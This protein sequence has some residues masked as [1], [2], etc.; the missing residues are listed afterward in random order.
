MLNRTLTTTCRA[1]PLMMGCMGSAAILLWST[2]VACYPTETVY[3]WYYRA[4]FQMGTEILFQQGAKFDPEK[5][6]ETSVSEQKLAEEKKKSSTVEKKAGGIRSEASNHGWTAWLLLKM[7]LVG[8]NR[9]LLS[10]EDLETDERLRA[11]YIEPTTLA[12]V[13]NQDAPVQRQEARRTY[14]L[15]NRDLSFARLQR[16][17]LR[18]ADFSGAQLQGAGLRGANLQNARFGCN[19]MGRSLPG[20]VRNC[21]VQTCER[22]SCRA[23]T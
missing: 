2:V 16:V 22:L 20:T 3:G 21:K 19:P 23:R 10:D 14:K 17:D 9:L 11:Q 4:S 15:F 1:I 5:G 18:N 8:S 12:G 7:P 13:Q 6:K